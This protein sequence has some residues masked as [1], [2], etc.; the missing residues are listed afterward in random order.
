MVRNYIR[1]ATLSTPVFG[2]D[3]AEIDTFYSKFTRPGGN[4]A[5]GEKL[6]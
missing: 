5:G 3:R 4:G 2:T 1:E 6:L